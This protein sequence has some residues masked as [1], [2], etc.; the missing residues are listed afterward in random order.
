MAG[1]Q[2][3]TLMVK[4]CSVHY[5]EAGNKKGLD[6]I[7]LHGMKFNAATWEELGTLKALAEK[8]FHVLAVDMPGFGESPSCELDN[9]TVLNGV[10]EQLGLGKIVL[11]GPSMGGKT[12]LEFVIDDSEKISGLVLVGAVGVEENKT[13][14]SA[15]KV[16]VFLIWGGED[17]VSPLTNSEILLEGINDAKRMVFAGSPHPCY[18]DQP[19][20]WHAELT[21]FL[22]TLTA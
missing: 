15:I 14:L 12:A 3:R 16:P 1:I 5:L 9:N 2:S 19:D 22:A 6:I 8:G 18:L 11:V 20:R 13:S 4:D 21:S 7:L 17:Q 10:I